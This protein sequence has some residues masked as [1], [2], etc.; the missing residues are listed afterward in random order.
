HAVADAAAALEQGLK[1]T[2]PRE[3]I[4]PRLQTLATLLQPLLGQLA[5]WQAEATPAP[6]PRALAVADEAA[7]AA[8]DPVRLGQVSRQL[9]TLLAEGDFHA[10][11]FLQ[12]HGDLL[13]A[14]YSAAH[15]QILAC[16]R[17]FDFEGALG[18]LRLAAANLGLALEPL[19]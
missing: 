18:A 6:D 14:A 9:A 17:A 8:I 1:P 10:A 13:A 16:V 3:D 12:E 2:A 19:P 7:H 4:A 15:G 5:R 11:A